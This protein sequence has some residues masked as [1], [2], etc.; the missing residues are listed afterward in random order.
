ML[1][2][3]PKPV[4][5]IAHAIAIDAHIHRLGHPAARDPRPQRR[6]DAA[7]V[8]G[9]AAAA[10]VHVARQPCLVGWVAD[11]EHALDGGEAG[12]GEPDDVARAA[13]FL[14]SDAADY[15]IGSTLTVDGGMSLYP[16]FRDN[17]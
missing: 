16:G 4:G 7:H 1:R 13:L 5:A 15:I 3:N 10:V 2:V 14:V 11:E 12:A 6:R 8:L 9:R 17:G